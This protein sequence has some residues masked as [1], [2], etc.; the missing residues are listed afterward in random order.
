VATPCALVLVTENLEAQYAALPI[1]R[2]ATR[3]ALRQV[4][5]RSS[6]SPDGR[7]LAVAAGATTPTATAEEGGIYLLPVD[8]GQP[9]RLTEGKSLGAALFAAWVPVNRVTRI[10]PQQALRYE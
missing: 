8:G 5:G 6:W 7:W 10:D 9:C 3:R 4:K 1:R 2:P